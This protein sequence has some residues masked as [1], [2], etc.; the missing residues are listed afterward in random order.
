MTCFDDK[1]AFAEAFGQLEVAS[2]PEAVRRL[3]D[4]G[5]E[6]EEPKPAKYPYKLINGELVKVDG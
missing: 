2:T 5:R 6:S 1:D 3:I 4:K